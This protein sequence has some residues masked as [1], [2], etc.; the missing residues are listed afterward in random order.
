M[1]RDQ[2]TFVIP[3]PRA[4]TPG[5]DQPHAQAEVILTPG[6]GVFEATPIGGV[7]E[8]AS[9]L[10]ADSVQWRTT[11]AGAKAAVTLQ[12]TPGEKATQD[13]L[14][15]TI[16]DQRSLQIDFAELKDGR[17][18]L[19]RGSIRIALQ[20]GALKNLLQ[21]LWPVHDIGDIKALRVEPSGLFLEG[22]LP[23]A[24]FP[25]QTPQSDGKITVA[26]RAPQQARDIVSADA[27]PR[28]G[29]PFW[30]LTAFDFGNGLTHAGDFLLRYA[31]AIEGYKA[32]ASF[33]DNVV[34]SPGAETVVRIFAPQDNQVEWVA[35]KLREQFRVQLG[36]GEAG[37]AAFFPDE[38]AGKVEKK[39]GGWERAVVAQ[40]AGT[41][42]H[43]LL[44][45]TLARVENANAPTAQLSLSDSPAALKLENQQLTSLSLPAAPLD[46]QA[47]A[48]SRR[49]EKAKPPLYRSWL[50]TD[51]GWLALDAIA[52]PPQPRRAGEGAIRGVVEIEKIL[53]H[54]RAA[55]AAQPAAQEAAAPTEGSP[56]ADALQVQFT[57]GDRTA[58]VLGVDLDGEGSGTVKGVHLFLHN[59]ITTVITPSVWYAAA[60]SAADRPA[61]AHLLPSLSA[62]ANDAALD[63]VFQKAT[64][65][66]PPPPDK[67]AA[68]AEQQEQT[69]QPH[70]ASAIVSYG[71]V[72]EDE[73][74]QFMVEVQAH[75]LQLWHPLPNLPLAQSFSRTPDPSR[76]SF[77][78]AN[79]GLIPFE[80]T[81]DPD[82]IPVI[83]LAFENLTGLPSVPAAPVDKENL[84]GWTI[85]ASRFP[86]RYFLPTLP[87]LEATLPVKP[88]GGAPANGLRWGYRHAVPALDE[89][90]AEVTED[91]QEDKQVQTQ[92]ALDF[93]RVQGAEAFDVGKAGE[94]VSAAGWLLRS[95][96]NPNGQ[97]KDVTIAEFRPEGRDPSLKITIPDFQPD[98]S[99]HGEPGTFSRTSN[100]AGL[101]GKLNGEPIERN[102]QSLGV[103]EDM[104][105]THDGNGHQVEAITSQDPATTL[106][107]IGP[108]GLQ[109][110]VRWTG[111]YRLENDA[112][113]DALSL[114]L[115]GV[116]LG[117]FEDNTDLTGQSWMLHDGAGDWPSLRGW[118]LFPLKLLSLEKNSDALTAIVEAVLLPRTPTPPVFRLETMM[119]M[120]GLATK[121][122]GTNLEG[123]FALSIPDNRKEINIVLSHK[124]WLPH[125]P[126]IRL[127]RG[128]VLP[129]KLSDP[130]PE[131]GNSLTY[132]IERAGEPAFFD[133]TEHILELATDRTEVTWDTR[134]FAG[135]AIKIT[136]ALDMSDGSL[137]VTSVAQ[138]GSFDWRFP[139]LSDRDVSLVRLQGQVTQLKDM[140]TQGSQ[141][142]EMMF[143]HPLGVI[144]FGRVSPRIDLSKLEEQEFKSIDADRDWTI[145]LIPRRGEKLEPYRIKNLDLKWR[146][147]CGDE[148]SLTLHYEYNH[149]GPDSTDLPSRWSLTIERMRDNVYKSLVGPLRLEMHAIDENKFM[150]N[151]A[152]DQAPDTGGERAWL[153]PEVV[154]G[155]IGVAFS[156]DRQRIETLSAELQ[157]S[158]VDRYPN[159]AILLW[160]PV[161]ETLRSMDRNVGRLSGNTMLA[162]VVGQQLTR[163]N[164]PAEELF[165]VDDRGRL[166]RWRLVDENAIHR[167]D[168]GNKLVA[169]AAPISDPTSGRLFCVLDGDIVSV[170]SLQIDTDQPKKWTIDDILVSDAPVLAIATG[171]PALPESASVAWVTSQS[172]HY[173][174]RLSGAQV[175][176]VSSGLASG[177]CI[178]QT[179]K[180]IDHQEI[181]NLVE[182]LVEIRDGKLRCWQATDGV[183]EDIQINDVEA[184]QVAAISGPWL[185]VAEGDGLKL[186]NLASLVKG[187]APVLQEIEMAHP[188]WGEPQSIV[189][190]GDIN[191]G[192]EDRTHFAVLYGPSQAQGATCVRS[193]V[194]VFD[195]SKDQVGDVTQ[196]NRRQ[197]DVGQCCPTQLGVMR[198]SGNVTLLVLSGPTSSSRLHAQMLLDSRGL[199]AELTGR[200]VLQNALDYRVDGIPSL[201]Q[202]AEPRC[203]HRIDLYFD[204]AAAPAEAIFWSE[205]HAA[206]DGY[207]AA[208]AQHTFRFPGGQ[209]R[210]WQ[211]P[212]MVRFTSLKRF[213]PLISRAVDEIPSERQA[214]LVLDASAVFWL[215]P[216]ARAEEMRYGVGAAAIENDKFGLWLLPRELRS[217]E[218]GLARAVRVPAATC[219]AFDNAPFE[220]RENA[221]KAPRLTIAD[222]GPDP[223]LEYW[224]SGAQ[225]TLLRP[226][227]TEKASLLCPHTAPPEHR[228]SYFQ[229]SDEAD[230]LDARFL[231]G[232]LHAPL[233]S[234]DAASSSVTVGVRPV[235]PADPN[236]P[237]AELPTTLNDLLW[238]TDQLMLWLHQ[239]VRLYQLELQDQGQP[240]KPADLLEKIRAKVAKWRRPLEN[241]AASEGVVL[242][243]AKLNDRTTFRQWLSENDQELGDF[244]GWL[245]TYTAGES[246]RPDFISGDSA[247]LASATLAHQHNS[248]EPRPLHGPT[249]FEFPY[250]LRL[251]EKTWLDKAG[252]AGSKFDVQLVVFDTDKLKGGKLKRLASDRIAIEEG[253]HTD[254]KDAALRWARGLMEDRRRFDAA[255]VL[256]DYNEVIPVPR[257]FEAAYETLSSAHDAPL[258]SNAGAGFDPR[259]RLPALRLLE[260]GAWQ[261]QWVKA[262]LRLGLRLFAA[263]PARPA[264]PAQKTVAATHFRLAPAAKE[265]KPLGIARVEPAQDDDP[266]GR[267]KRAL[268]GVS[269]RDATPFEVYGELAYPQPDGRLRFG[270]Q[271]PALVGS[272]LKQED[273][274]PTDHGEAASLLP[275]L[276]DVVSWAARPGEMMAS[277]WVANEYKVALDGRLDPDNALPAAL[278][279][280][281][282]HAR[283]PASASLRRPRAQAGAH[284]AVRL[285]AKD[286]SPSLRFFDRFL[287]AEFVLQQ[288]LD[289]TTKEDLDKTGVQIVVVTRTDVFKS[290]PTIA[291]AM[292]NPAQIYDTG[293]AD[294]Y[295]VT[296]KQFRDANPQDDNS[297]LV[298]Q[299]LPLNW[300]TVQ[301]DPTMTT[302]P[303]FESPFE[304]LQLGLRV[305]QG[306]TEEGGVH[307]RTYQFPA[308]SLDDTRTLALLRYSKILKAD[309]TFEYVEPEEPMV[310][311]V[312]KLLAK[313]GAFIP[314]KMSV[315]LLAGPDGAVNLAG[316]GR[317]GPEDFSLIEPRPDA[318]GLAWSRTAILRAVHRA[319]GPQVAY[320]VVVY[321]PGGELIRTE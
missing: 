51:R 206:G 297:H 234:A 209:E 286:G 54:L 281:T 175:K 129:I 245:E 100:V 276:V 147:Q 316:Y 158:M 219:W 8:G 242:P 89:A 265:A 272:E 140:E 257:R 126:R 86:T 236:D 131:Q 4:W 223:H 188:N 9:G 84:N 190:L 70:P 14:E 224:S 200:L 64:F 24:I 112:Q 181:D 277:S 43:L 210:I 87:G 98:P 240:L 205:H 5:D 32:G 195:C 38:M 92:G 233:L 263:Y 75:R 292:S 82:T 204:R 104:T 123:S 122:T 226:G 300:D 308:G 320:D 253:T 207:T 23:A 237:N 39:N 287:R 167:L 120:D 162:G 294:I 49:R 212:Q 17:H 141:L 3:L 232:K 118:P 22:A 97:V 27:D 201:P 222:H 184:T 152:P 283:H 256:L 275:P 216:A 136:F 139:P 77:M 289:S 214:A 66:S 173:K 50:C 258:D 176:A 61:A 57:T 255:Y 142:T 187:D 68:D 273:G 93:T 53:A 110:E 106:R 261:Q 55:A 229:R 1:E 109:E 293:A 52:S 260:G 304:N 119:V 177:L 157:V 228:P 215:Q 26:L 41:D 183:L 307:W 169:L 203:T 186:V 107:Y 163:N 40:D 94:T 321:G 235:F 199:R 315:S 314:P 194:F 310:A 103:L 45:T 306:H 208:L 48:H 28:K 166:R 268:L 282:N 124:R 133:Q 164:T 127:K 74:E 248:A 67:P 227:D 153:K 170:A 270:Q 238:L 56:E 221:L 312:V 252:A 36:G 159:D 134:P 96:S 165:W 135:G 2:L 31:Q 251:V 42:H 197:V 71:R 185:V 267:R 21:P 193:T 76:D 81:T 174:E 80:P 62:L 285:K 254:R 278:Q 217:F 59:P 218:T 95:D 116:R 69:R 10:A 149:P 284:E 192:D 19:L 47:P 146:F 102:G 243:E 113:G 12:K 91:P 171:L 220:V 249:L 301:D 130:L 182:F 34:A 202:N 317:L 125:P 115:M 198:R 101:S 73:P 114:E 13:G 250:R 30:T 246:L 60:L 274:A 179:K 151:V 121:A 83:T 88:K 148:T 178:A 65:V 99:A 259:R 172:V 302:Q 241:Q 271:P 318:D 291:L 63:A 33:V 16:T 85:P 58:V 225:P 211:A 305:D 6:G 154:T 25:P 132:K 137:A 150:F 7:L 180:V 79:R 72:K 138:D 239:H 296:T 161:R 298:L 160:D 168:E 269:Q 111:S 144:N 189:A 35:P 18:V 156:P 309:G 117:K 145:T 311:I 295:L 105:G 230:W 108:Q 37:E 247:F 128:V 143:R 46:P 319:M 266:Q 303:Y 290:S 78:D 213:A 264:D 279:Q 244:T 288:D 191:V 15:V 313:T 262:D 20:D 11:A 299:L 29:Q 44:Q 280:V 155:V 90:Y 196:W 231:G